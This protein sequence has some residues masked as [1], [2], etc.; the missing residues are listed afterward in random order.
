MKLEMAFSPNHEQKNL[1]RAICVKNKKSAYFVVSDGIKE[2]SHD[3]INKCLKYLYH[4]LCKDSS[5]KKIVSFLKEISSKHDAKMSICILEINRN[6]KAKI[7]SLGDC[8]LY[9]N[10]KLLTKDHSL[11]WKRLEERGIEKNIIEENVAESSLRHKLYNCFRK[12]FFFV[13]TKIFKLKKNDEIII[14][15]D[16]VWSKMHKKIKTKKFFIR[17]EY[18]N[19]RDDSLTLKILIK[20]YGLSSLKINKGI[21][22]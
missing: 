16:G 20:K 1:D 9:L 22:P 17:K 14:C 21:F 4:Y 13:D 2:S 7:Y 11:F 10:G 15:T 18:N 6:Y 3:D 12:E 5:T 8:R 19:R